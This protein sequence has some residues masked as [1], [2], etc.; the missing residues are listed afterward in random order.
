MCVGTCVYECD[1][2]VW[3]A[4]MCLCVHMC[5]CVLVWC[6]FVYMCLCISV[7]PGTLKTSANNPCVSLSSHFLF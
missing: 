2:F 5:M 1:V 3:F 6:A 4:F 7:C